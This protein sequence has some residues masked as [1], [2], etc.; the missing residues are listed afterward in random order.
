VTTFRPLPRQAPRRPL[1][2]VSSGAGGFGSTAHLV[3]RFL[4]SLSPRPP[5]TADEAWARHWLRPG[6]RALW[7]RQANPDRRHAIGVA[8]TVAT[9]LGDADG[10]G[11]PREVLAAALLH[12]VGKIE[13]G[14]GTF[15]RVAATVV[16]TAVGRDKVAG[17]S[18]R[19]GWRGRAGRYVTH[20]Q[21]GG[22]LL[23]AADSTPFTATWAREH[24]QPEV[25]W[26]LDPALTSLLKEADGD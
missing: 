10:T 8:R 16:A 15:G 18:G 2:Q 1:A 11:A 19:S 9:G 22:A 13:A 14:L 21:R 6:E 26:T 12:D 25:T 17:W 3:T 20:D 24:H 5:S 4:G 7:D 23:A